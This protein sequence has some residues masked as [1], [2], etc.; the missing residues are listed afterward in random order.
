MTRDDLAQIICDALWGKRDFAYRN[1]EI[2]E[3]GLRV[4]D[5]VLSHLPDLPHPDPSQHPSTDRG[6]V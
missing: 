2:K 1:D 3:V 4:A 6:S 5:A